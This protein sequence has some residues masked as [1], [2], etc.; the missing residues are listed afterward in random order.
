MSKN[1]KQKLVNKSSN[2]VW[3]LLWGVAA[4]TV[5]FK[6]DFYDPFNSAKLILLLLVDGWIFGHLINSYRE[7][8]IK[9]NS[10]ESFTTIIVACFILL[11]LVSTLLTDVFMVGLLGD[12][13]R[14]NGFLAYFGLS[15]IFLY[16]S[17]S[18]N[19]LNVLRVYKIGISTGL[20]LSTYGLIQISGNDFI[21]WNNPYNAMISTLGNP[22][23]ASA[24][25]AVLS[26]LALYGLFLKSLPI[27]YKLLSLIF[28]ISALICIII[29]GSRQGLLV[30]FFS[31]LFY[32][33]IYF[34]L[35]NKQIG[36]F[37]ICVGAFSA[38]LALLGMLQKGPLVSLLYKD[39]VSVRGYYWRA[40]IEMF[41]N[42]PF[43]G[44][45][46]DR[47]GAY[48]KEFREV[49]YPLKYGYEITSSNAHNTF[50]QLFATAGILVG[51]VYLLLIGY[52]LFSAI[53]LLKR[54]NSEDQK[55][56]LGLLSAWVGFQ[57]QS[58]ISIDN[59]GISIWGWLLGGAILGLSRE[60]KGNLEQSVINQV[61][62]KI[63][64]RVKINLFQPAISVLVLVP[65]IIFS[66]LFYKSESNLFYLKIITV[67][68]SPQNK[69]PV[70]E[71][72]N[73]VV[74]NPFSDPF[75][76]FRAAFLLLDMGFTD[77][78]YK[79]IL[80]LHTYDSKNLDYLQGLAYF[81][82]I[83]KNIPN[84]TS[85]RN[86]IV[87]RDPWNADNYLQL[88]KLYMVNNDLT[89]ATAMKNKI[90]SFAPNSQAAK[91]ALEIL[92]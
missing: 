39:S 29:S 57:A 92:G 82:E 23:F 19:F 14:R 72:A 28:I 34:Y 18:I 84:A 4:V 90:L 42:K 26:L 50:I 22:N 52:V 76:K 59:I 30:I 53:N 62:P 91:S 73:K 63:S 66:S 71:Y 86:K 69:Q 8:P 16:A 24:L 81:E 13:Q 6:T 65:I 41:K 31:L 64:N 27:I 80:K 10:T 55:I 20:I 45:G 43:T 85:V 47:Y 7:T 12:T 44:V 40:G 74:D 37:V 9:F 78:S 36:F 77:E 67:P 25:L 87:E 49:G 60:H 68:T 35:K 5:F 38:I 75:Y 11:L 48:F 56:T 54:S 21:K 15:I 17:R 46:V 79:V 70:L 89:N 83:R 88:L 2:S 51:I 58:L 61:T 1:N 32:S 33:S 3:F